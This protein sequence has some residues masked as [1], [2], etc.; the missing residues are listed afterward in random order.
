MS[1]FKSLLPVVSTWFERVL[2][3]VTARIGD[4]PT[5]LD[6]LWDPATCPVA[7]LPWLAWAVSVD[8]WSDA[9][10]E[11]T[12]RGMIANSIAMH[13][14]KGTPLAIELAVAPFGLSTEII[15]WWQTVPNGTPGTW[16]LRVKQNG[17]S[18]LA[19]TATLSAQVR[20]AVDAARPVSRPMSLE[21]GSETSGAVEIA[22]APRA[23]V[24][25]VIQP[26]PGD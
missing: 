2:E 17:T 7:H 6:T 10:P 23:R 20:A 11:A 26:Y 8:T 15:E 21:V 4:V 1:V 13:R 18:D 24:V 5:P 19:Y 16:R 25:A 14:I 9:W 12:K 3:R 22:G